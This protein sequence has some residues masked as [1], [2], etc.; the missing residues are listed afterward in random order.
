MTTGMSSPLHGTSV[1]SLDMLETRLTREGAKSVPKIRGVPIHSVSLMNPTG[2]PSE[3]K[4][5]L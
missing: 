5:L 3:E 2:I 4:C 1:V